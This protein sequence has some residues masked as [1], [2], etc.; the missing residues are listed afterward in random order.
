[1]VTERKYYESNL[2]AA[3]AERAESIG[4][5][6]DFHDQGRFAGYMVIQNEDKSKTL[7]EVTLKDDNG[8]LGNV[9][10]KSENV[11]K[12]IDDIMELMKDESRDN[13][14]LGFQE[15]KGKNGKTFIKVTMNIRVFDE[16][17][18]K[19]VEE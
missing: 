10:T 4:L 12:Q 3:V 2:I 18:R 13:W 16:D 14:T 11:L 5:A 7:Y 17:D 9:V 1:M 15:Q 19:A 6:R 8:F